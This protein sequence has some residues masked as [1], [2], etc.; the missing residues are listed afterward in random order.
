MSKDKR[1]KDKVLQ[2]ELEKIYDTQFLWI[3]TG[4]VLKD[5]ASDKITKA[6][7]NNPTLKLM[8]KVS[9]ATAVGVYLMLFYNILMPIPK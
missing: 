5:R 6:L 7:N 4:R 3:E 1:D 8:L 9:I 2:K